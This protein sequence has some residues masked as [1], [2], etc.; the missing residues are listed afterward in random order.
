M[1]Y[2]NVADLDLERNVISRVLFYTFGAN[3]GQISE[4]SASELC[5]V[6]DILHIE[7]GSFFSFTLYQD[8]FTYIHKCFCEDKYPSM[9]ELTKHIQNLPKYKSQR[10]AIK[11]Q[12]HQLVDLCES[13]IFSLNS[14]SIIDLANQLVVNSRMR[15]I[16]RRLENGVNSPEE[17]SIIKNLI[18]AIEEP[19][20]SR[21]KLQRKIEQ[22]RDSKDPIDKIESKRAMRM[23]GFSPQEVLEVTDNFVPPRPIPKI[24]SALD[25]LNEKFSEAS[26]IYPGLIKSGVVNL[27][28][29]Q[30]GSGKTLFC[31][32]CMLSFLSSSDFIGE[33]PSRIVMN[34]ENRGLIINADQPAVDAQEML[35]NNPK[36]WRLARDGKYD[37]IS[38]DWCLGDI[39]QLEMLLRDKIYNFVV[40]DSY[41]AI[42][43]HLYGW[44][45]NHPSASMGIKELQKLCTL[46]GCTMLLIHHAGNTQEKGRHKSRGHSSIP[47]TA[48]SVLSISA[49]VIDDQKG[50]PNIRFLEISKTRNSER[51]KLTLKF[52]PLTYS[53]ELLPDTNGLERGR[54]NTLANNLMIEFKRVFP[55]LLSVD[56]LLKKV[57]GGD[58]K[59]LLA[60]ALQKLEQRGWVEKIVDE[61]SNEFY[62]KLVANS[63]VVHL[64]S[65][66]EEI[67]RDKRIK[68]VFD[69]F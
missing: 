17:V 53:Y 27:V 31:Y 14:I 11:H 16:N 7:Q 15:E 9:W 63:N 68:E 12:I 3:L 18:S 60:K 42:H 5:Q 43:S 21:K 59:T 30:G 47:D 4:N 33:S 50:D 26:W 64:K 10:E 22:Y 48:S 35:K 25:F 67:A 8:L 34:P 19:T 56:E 55:D 28:T 38:T 20:S 40:I 49:S 44:D 46:Y 13:T 37:I 2:F 6:L 52:N 41:K 36:A 62:Y 32:E 51:T 57:S 69:D 45:E 66:I 29:G 65:A 1:E 58:R 24:T 61:V 23:M 54:I 39:L